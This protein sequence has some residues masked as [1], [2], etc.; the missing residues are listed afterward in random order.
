M[1]S[2]LSLENCADGKLILSMIKSGKVPAAITVEA[3]DIQNARDY[4][5]SIAA[6]IMCS[7]EDSPCGQCK[8]CRKILSGHPD[9][10]IVNPKKNVKTG[11]VGP[12]EI[13]E[14]CQDASI[15]PNDGDRKIYIFHAELT[16]AAQNTLLKI[17]EEPP[18]GVTFII[19]CVS[20]QSLLGTILSRATSL[21]FGG[22]QVVAA[23]PMAEEIAGEMYRCI[24]KGDRGEFA[25]VSAKLKGNRSLWKECL[26]NLRFLIQQTAVAKVKGGNTSNPL[27]VRGVKH[28]SSSALMRMDDCL[29]TLITRTETNPNEG[30]FVVAL[31]LRMFE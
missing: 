24:V 2:F 6:A 7:E 20:E 5:L 12:T 25:V 9:V 18:Q 22:Q 29:D 30:L 14:V 1:S 16:E 21:S 28:L 8:V 11:T 4:A 3:P 23:N 19:P 17:F 13:R 31:N 26:S 10:I 15:K 27:I